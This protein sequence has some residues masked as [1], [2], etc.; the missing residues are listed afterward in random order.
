MYILAI[1]V[2]P[3]RAVHPLSGATNLKTQTGSRADWI[4]LTIRLPM[5]SGMV[6]PQSTGKTIRKIGFGR[7]IVIKCCEAHHTSGV[8]VDD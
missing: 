3:E 7:G 8:V 5:T 4:W 1:N 6:V 2:A